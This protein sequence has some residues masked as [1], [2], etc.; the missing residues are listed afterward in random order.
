MKENNGETVLGVVNTRLDT[1]LFPGWICCPAGG[2][3]QLLWGL[4]QLQRGAML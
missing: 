3:G 2:W 1:Q 4:P